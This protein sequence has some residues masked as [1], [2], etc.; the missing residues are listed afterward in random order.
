MNSN[1]DSIQGLE[2]ALI[3][4]RQHNFFR[5]HDS[6][7]RLAFFSLIK[8]LASG[9]GMGTRSDNFGLPLDNYSIANRVYSNSGRV[10]I[11]IDRTN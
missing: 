5:M 9:V 11:E 3:D 8:G 1:Q 4:L 10:G 7:W 6:L 2:R